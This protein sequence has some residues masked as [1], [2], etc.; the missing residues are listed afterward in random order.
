MLPS[1]LTFEAI[2]RLQL[3]SLSGTGEYAENADSPCMVGVGYA[4][5][6]RWE[7]ISDWE[8]RGGVNGT[9]SGLVGGIMIFLTS[10]VSSFNIISAAH[11]NSGDIGASELSANAD[12]P[13]S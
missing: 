2:G 13:C 5:D 1:T 7:N 4:E 3:A 10:V 11:V 6:S 8:A 12:C 9:I